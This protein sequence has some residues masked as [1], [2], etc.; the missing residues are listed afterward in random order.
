M[1]PEFSYL[2]GQPAGTGRLKTTPEDFFVREHLNF[3]PSGEGEHLLIRVRKRGMNTAFVAKKLAELVEVPARQVGWAGL[4][5]RHAVTEQWFA[6]HLPGKA[7]PD[8]S[9]LESDELQI[10]EV[11][12]HNK[13][14]RTGAL[15]GND[16][17]LVLRELSDPD[18]VM[19]RLERLKE[20]GVPNYYGLQRFGRD[21]KNIERAA[22]M[23]GGARVRDKMQRSM[24]LSS[25]RSLLFNQ[26]VSERLSQELATTL[27][28]GDCV[29]LR[30]SRSFFSEPEL[31]D[32]LLERFASGDIQLSAPLWGRG[33]LGS[34][35]AAR[36]LEQSALS[37]F[38]D[39]CEGLE[40]AGMKQERRALMLHPEALDWQLEG[41]MLTLSFHLPSGSF[42][43]SVVRELVQA[44]EVDSER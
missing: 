23:F 8:L 29:M 6:I 20:L 2:Q 32:E 16:F 30:G 11:T 22:A 1:I 41:D 9:P 38:A 7:M 26:V 43:T 42:A 36:E 33:E 27:M 15:S 31:S 21:G 44:I 5:D 35:G 18:E 14:M 40:K 4:K 12:R 13:K 17:K 34:Q 25:A 19:T 37:E 28:A 10:L 24:A 39:F 3:T